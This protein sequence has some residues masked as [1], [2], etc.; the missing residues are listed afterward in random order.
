[1]FS[2][3]DGY[4][5]FELKDAWNLYFDVELLDDYLFDMKRE[6]SDDSIFQLFSS[7][8][9]YLML[10]IRHFIFYKLFINGGKKHR[11]SKFQK[12]AISDIRKYLKALS[13]CQMSY[14]SNVF[15]EI[16]EIEDD[17]SMLQMVLCVLG[18]M[19]C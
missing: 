15:K 3:F 12:R 16:S 8:S 17:F 2:E 4:D 19:W 14:F 7:D 5:Y 9:Y 6:V 18:H 11:H 13:S 10:F 1:M